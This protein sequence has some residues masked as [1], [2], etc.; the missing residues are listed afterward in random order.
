MAHRDVCGYMLL[1]T[2]SG[3]RIRKKRITNGSWGP[4]D[5]MLLMYCQGGTVSLFDR[6]IKAS[7]WALK[8]ESRDAVCLAS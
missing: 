1:V 7:V 2:V 5:S 3:P 8:Y 6:G 4:S